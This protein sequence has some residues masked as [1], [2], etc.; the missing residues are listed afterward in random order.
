V[1]FLN[2]SSSLHDAQPEHCP[3]EGLLSLQSS[4]SGTLSSSLSEG[5]LTEIVIVSESVNLLSETSNVT[6]YLPTSERRGV[7]ENTLLTNLAPAGSGA[8]QSI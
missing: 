7:H 3:I 6:L 5:F 8:F 1:L 4:T 2:L